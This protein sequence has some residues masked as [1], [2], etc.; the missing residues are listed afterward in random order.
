ML[1]SVISFLRPAFLNYL[2]SVR[3]QDD[4]EEGRGD[5]FVIWIIKRKVELLSFI[6]H[7][8]TMTT[9]STNKMA[10][11][12]M[13]LDALEKLRLNT[14]RTSWIRG[15]APEDP[16]TKSVVDGIIKRCRNLRI[17]DSVGFST[18][19]VKKVAHSCPMLEGLQFSKYPAIK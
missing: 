13:C 4:T 8:T 5:N 17:L 1:Q 10:N 14:R 11:G 6:A 18:S 7:H 19:S 16:I 3:L 2:Q 9:V 12:M 15:R